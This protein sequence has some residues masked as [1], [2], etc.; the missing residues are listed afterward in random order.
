MEEFCCGCLPLLGVTLVNCQSK[1][2]LAAAYFTQANT[3]SVS[4]RRDLNA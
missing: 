4:R 1:R 2:E 3:L